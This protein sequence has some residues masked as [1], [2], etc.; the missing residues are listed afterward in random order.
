MKREWSR[1][2][3]CSREENVPIVS[4]TCVNL[5]I[6]FRAWTQLSSIWLQFI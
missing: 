1:V 3:L 6:F 2:G 4:G 5:H